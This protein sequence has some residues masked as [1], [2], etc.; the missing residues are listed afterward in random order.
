MGD[1]FQRVIWQVHEFCSNIIRRYSLC[2]IEVHERLEGLQEGLREGMSSGIGAMGGQGVALPNVPEGKLTELSMQ[3]YLLT[4][5]RY[6]RC[7]SEVSKL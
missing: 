7:S 1:Q 6:P 4:R 2:N 3:K 5:G